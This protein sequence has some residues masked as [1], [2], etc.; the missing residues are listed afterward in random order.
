MVTATDKPYQDLWRTYAG[1]PLG[2]PQSD[3]FIEI[4]KFYFDPDEA[5][6]AARMD[7]QPE[8]EEVIAARAGIVLEE[9]SDLLT[10]MSSKLFIVGFRR[11]DG[12]RTFRLKLVAV[13]D[14]LF[15]TPLSSF[16]I[17]HRTWSVLVTFGTS[18]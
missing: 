14:G 10:R 8:P 18:T 9:A 1:H 11:P 5:A 3:T 17:L 16:G 4:L 12:T 13:G 7:F 6:L 15:E 2:A